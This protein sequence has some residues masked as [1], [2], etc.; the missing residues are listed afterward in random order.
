MNLYR[1]DPIDID[2]TSWAAS[3]VKE[4]VWV[5]AAT[6]RAARDFV[7]NKTLTVVNPIEKF[8]PKVNSPW[9]DDRVTSCVWET[10]G[11]K[12]P[13]GTVVRADWKPLP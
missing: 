8:S 11:R 12:L 13:E 5:G 6:D 10:D 4:T 9:L 7:A 2:H 1:L 3:S